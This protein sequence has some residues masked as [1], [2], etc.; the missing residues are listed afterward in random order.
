MPGRFEI[1]AR[2]LPQLASVIFP[3][4]Y[5]E[6]AGFQPLDRFCCGNSGCVAAK[7]TLIGAGVNHPHARGEERF[8]IH[9]GD[10]GKIRPSVSGEKSRDILWGGFEKDGV[11][12]G[13]HV[14]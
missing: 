1:Y 2:A 4:A 11:L 6:V 12:R 8:F 5:P 10:G 7:V 14:A 3:N 9:S 13:V